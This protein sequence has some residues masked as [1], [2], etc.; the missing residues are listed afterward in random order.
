M[1]APHNEEYNFTITPMGVYR[2]V[3]AEYCRSRLVKFEGTSTSMSTEEKL[4]QCL[5][6]V[7]H[8]CTSVYSRCDQ[9]LPRSMGAQ[10]KAA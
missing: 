3:V 8:E 5:T 4:K 2:L 1:N 7:L 9:S 6:D 10:P